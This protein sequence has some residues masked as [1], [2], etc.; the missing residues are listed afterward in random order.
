M[1]RNPKEIAA[2]ALHL[3]PKAR[4]DLAKRLLE[5]L[6][7]LS[8]EERDELW[9]GEAARRYA[10]FKKGAAKAVSG[11]DVFARARARKH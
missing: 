5:S 11:R 9:A 1:R 2:E 3:D 6:E 4:A 10:E 7:T 8:Q